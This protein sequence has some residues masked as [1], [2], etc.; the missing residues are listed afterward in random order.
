MRITDDLCDMLQ[1]YHPLWM[2]IHVNH[3]NEITH[4]LAEACDQEQR[5]EFLLTI[6]SLRI[7]GGTGSPV[8]PL[9]QF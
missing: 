2:N 1:K 4:E 8:N 6:A 7:P 3:P 9:A 5:W